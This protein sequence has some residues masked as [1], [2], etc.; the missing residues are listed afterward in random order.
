MPA[1]RWLRSASASGDAQLLAGSAELEAGAPVEP[2]GTGTKALPAMVAVELAQVTKEFVS[3]G[4]DARRQLG[5]AVAEQIQVA[6]R[7]R[8]RR[9]CAVGNG[10]RRKS[11]SRRAP[12]ERCL[13]C[14]H[15]TP[16][17][18]CPH[19]GPWTSRWSDLGFAGQ[20][21]TRQAESAR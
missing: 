11:R 7:L 12:A 2:V 9:R 13:P 3:G 8:G 15:G 14:H 10:E 5:D 21:R 17:I 4:L 16:G 18:R 6:R 20:T 19:A 1:E